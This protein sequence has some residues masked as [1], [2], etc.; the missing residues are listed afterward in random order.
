[1]R[2]LPF[3]PVAPVRIDTANAG[4]SIRFTQALWYAWGRMDQGATL[5]GDAFHF[6]RD[7]ATLYRMFDGERMCAMP[8]MQRAYENWCAGKVLDTF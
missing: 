4:D 6:A 8:S 3:G 2:T 7:Y 1:M 5:P